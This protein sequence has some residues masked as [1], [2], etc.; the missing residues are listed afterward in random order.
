LAATIYIIFFQTPLVSKRELLAAFLVFIILLWLVY[1]L[2]DRFLIPTFR[3]Y[4]P[5]GKFLLVL[6]SFLFGLLISFSSNHTSIFF[7]FPEHSLVISVPESNELNAEDRQVSITWFSDG[8]QDVSFSQFSQTG[9]W[10]R[11]TDRIILSGDSSGSLEWKGKIIGEAKIE[12]ESNPQAGTV[13]VIWDGKAKTYDLT[14]KKMVASQVFSRNGLFDFWI[15]IIFFLSSSV[16]FLITT[17]FFLNIQITEEKYLAKKD[18]SWIFYA[19]PMVLVWGFFLY[20]VFP[21]LVAEDAWVQLQQVLSRNFTDHH[22]ILYALLMS[23]AN[24]IYPFPASVA[25]IQIVIIS[26]ALAWGL[27]ELN[28]MGVP[29]KVLWC[30]SVLFSLMPINLLSSVA[31]V[32]DIPYSVAILC[33]SIILLKVINTKGEWLTQGW[34]WLGLGSILGAIILFRING[35]PVALGSFLLLL[36]FYRNAWKRLAAAGGILLLLLALMYGPIYANLRVKH[37]PEFGTIL[38]LH[39]IA[40]HLDAGTS[41]TTEQETYLNQLAPINSWNYDCCQANPTMIAVFPGVFQQNYDLPL[42]RRDIFKPT[43]IALNLFLK[44]PIVD[45]KHMICTGQIIWSINSSCPDRTNLDTIKIDEQLS[46]LQNSRGPL[47]SYAKK[48]MPIFASGVRHNIN[49]VMAIY[50]YIAIFSTIIF[51]IRFKIWG[52]LLFIS[53]ILIQSTTLLLIGISQAYRYQ[54]GIALVGLLSLGL[55]FV[56][57]SKKGDS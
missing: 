5:K 42:L 34:H 9:N 32:K 23:L 36:I 35:L 27:N 57:L 19:L 30:L 7:L 1:L 46:A 53:P 51:S 24:R 15:S 25:I 16:L 11:E 8:W 31:I 29:R 44:N 4:T 45:I 13:Q 20:I 50:L 21:G 10:R 47:I 28:I 12:F 41:L 56:P 54:Y 40:A 39:H 2:T 33:L 17:L 48:Y 14:G 6:C 49:L 37:V 3:S 55:L 43:R 52:S 38:F 22:P 26:L 18:F